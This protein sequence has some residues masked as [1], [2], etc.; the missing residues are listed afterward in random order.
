MREDATFEGAYLIALSGYAYAEDQ[1]RAADA[2]FDRHI[3]KPV[4]VESLE[5]VLSQVN[6]S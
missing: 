6:R 3:A 5:R 4:D 2:G 1:T